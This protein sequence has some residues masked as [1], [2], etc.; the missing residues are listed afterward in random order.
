VT[1]QRLQELDSK[2][3]DMVGAAVSLE[4]VADT[5]TYDV[6]RVRIVVYKG[7]KDLVVAKQDADTM[8]ALREG[9]RYA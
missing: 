2:Q 7:P 8:M 3:A 5:T 1:E 6:H 4:K 9:A